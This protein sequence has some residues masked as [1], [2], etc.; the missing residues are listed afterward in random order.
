[1]MTS[2]PASTP[3]RIVFLP[4]MNGVGFQCKLRIDETPTHPLNDDEKM[5]MALPTKIR[6]EVVTGVRSLNHVCYE[7]WREIK[8]ERERYPLDKEKTMLKVA[9]LVSLF[10]LVFFFVFYE[11]SAY[12]TWFLQ[13]CFALL[14]GC[15]KLWL[16]QMGC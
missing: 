13:F 14:L 3:N 9:V 1:M 7:I 12:K 8:Y 11:D 10:C 6:E 4:N 16:I 2:C 15:C 5:V